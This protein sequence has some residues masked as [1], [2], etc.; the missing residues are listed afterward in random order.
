[1]ELNLSGPQDFSVRVGLSWGWAERFWVQ[2][3]TISVY[4]I[5][6]KWQQFV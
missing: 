6:D 3:M 2:G 4:N 1:M 5:S